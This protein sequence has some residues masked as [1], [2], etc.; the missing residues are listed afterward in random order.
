MANAEK[1][2]WDCIR[3]FAFIIWWLPF[4]A[5]IL[6]S[7]N[8]KYGDPHHVSAESHQILQDWTSSPFVD[9]V[10]TDENSCPETHPH[11]VFYKLAPGS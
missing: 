10:T 2:N 1:A 8:H 9:I 4:F 3:V 7:K 6:G 11:E 5:V